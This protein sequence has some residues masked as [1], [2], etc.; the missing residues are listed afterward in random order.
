MEAGLAEPGAAL[1]GGLDA[2]LEWNRDDPL[3]VELEKVFDGLL[4]NSLLYAEPAEPYRSIISFLTSRGDDVVH[5]ADCETRT[6]LHDL[7]IVPRFD[8]PEMVSRLRRRKSVIVKDGGILTWG[9]VSPEQAFIFFSSVCFACFVKFFTDFAY[10]LR[11]GDVDR[12]RKA[13]FRKVLDMLDPPPGEPP[14]LQKGPFQTQ[15]DVLSAIAEAGRETVRSRLVDSFFGNISYLHEGVLYISQTT[16]SLDELEGCID[17]CP[18]DGSSCASITASSEYTAHVEAVRDPAVNGILHGHPKF[19]VIMSMICDREGCDLR[20]RCHV[21]CPEARFVGDVP[22]VPGEVGTG[23]TGL[24]RTLPDALGGNRGVI[25]WGHGL[26]TPAG[27]D[28]NGAFGNLLD[29][30]VM[31]RDLYMQSVNLML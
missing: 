1:L 12:S 17:P 26:F 5:P 2:V 18:L 27:D 15:G 22:V 7:P 8:I 31:C 30:E 3:C 19:S 29:I 21:D 25:V 11:S 14:E 24:Y 28:F 9:T 20:G 6:F 23:P 13:L 10:D 16:S 4:I